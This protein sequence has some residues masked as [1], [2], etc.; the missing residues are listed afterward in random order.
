LPV[1]DEIDSRLQRG[2]DYT[3]QMID[4]M[5]DKFVTFQTSKENRKALR[6][7]EGGV[8][9]QLPN[10]S[11]RNTKTPN[12]KMGILIDLFAN[13]NQMLIFDNIK[14]ENGFL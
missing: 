4:D 6:K 14:L 7:K 12:E 5:Y 3:S 2:Y 13:N 8:D 11:E 9:F 1:F 10:I